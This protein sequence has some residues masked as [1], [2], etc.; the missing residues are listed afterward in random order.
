[1][2]KAETRDCT[3]TLVL[4]TMCLVS[5][6][7]EGSVCGRAA[8]GYLLVGV[9][10]QGGVRFAQTSGALARRLAATLDGAPPASAVGLE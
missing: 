7:D 8:G 4:P 5:L 3:S 10:H 1:M 9:L 6:E 2:R